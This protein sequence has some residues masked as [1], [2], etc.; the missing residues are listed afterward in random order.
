MK[1]KTLQHI[2]FALST[3]VLSVL[4][5]NVEPAQSQQFETKQMRVMTHMTYG[6]INCGW[7]S[8]VS[9]VR[10]K[11]AEG[12]QIVSVIP[13]QYRQRSWISNQVVNCVGENVSLIR[14]R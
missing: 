2:G 10:E 11:V 5:V 4:A 8:S 6:W 13:V 3:G 14:N 9:D 1:L 7:D 12:W